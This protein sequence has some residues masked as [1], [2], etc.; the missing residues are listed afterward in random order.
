VPRPKLNL[1]VLDPGSGRAQ[2]GAWV[3][4]YLANTLTLTT[5]WADD[6]VSTLANP[7][8][9]NQ[10]GQVA[11]RVNPGVYDISMAWDG[12]QP[13]IV[14]D[15]LA[16]TPEGAV[17]TTPGDL[18]VGGATG[19]TALHVG[20]ENQIL[21]VDQGMPSWRSLGSNDGAPT[22]TAGSLF[23]VASTGLVAPILPGTQDQALAMAGG[24]PTWVSTLLPPGTTLPIN[25]PG[26]L[27]YGA[28]GTGLPA[29]LAAGALGSVLTVSDNN[30]LVWSE[31][32]AV[33]PGVGQ[34]YLAYDGGTDLVLGPYGGNKIWVD[35]RS[36]VIPD[37]GVHLAPTGLAHYHAYYIYLAWTGS[38]L[39][40]EAS[41]TGYTQ[42]GGLW[43][44]TG[45]L[46]R[47]LVGYAW[48]DYNTTA[49]TPQWVDHRQL[50]G[51]LSLFNQDERTGDAWFTAPRSTTSTSLVE[52][53]AEIR[54]YF[55]AWAFS[56]ITM[57]M[58][59]TAYANVEGVAF[60]SVLALDSASIAATYSTST[61]VHVN[62]AAVVAKQLPAQDML[63]TLTL[64][65]NRWEGSPAGS[66][67]TWDGF[68]S[69]EGLGA[70]H[71]TFTLAT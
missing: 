59:G 46:S 37:A 56:N 11:M 70:C 14:E 23:T 27:V 25:Q 15:V 40:L 9:A 68:G 71:T 36:R 18:L 54:S 43:H 26:D 13:T 12:A 52:I 22:A 16:W 61:N 8:Q 19:S 4:I 55:V 63:H 41:L 32:G 44:K 33:G 65:G 39:A 17:L 30:T 20:Q 53:H 29:R 31:P 5:L 24:V 50:R 60:S 35:G 67:V 21:V 34:C 28:P 45:D 58:T 62:I 38:A 7:V 10:L 2:P 64:M 69:A 51:V 66:S 47:T 6:D 57:A 48:C 42:T 1:T 49:G 3:S